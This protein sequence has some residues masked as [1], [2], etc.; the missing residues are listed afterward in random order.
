MLKP[1]AF[2]IVQSVNPDANPTVINDLLE[3]S[4]AKTQSG[5][6]T[7]RPY[8]VA[9][10]TLSLNPPN[11]NLKKA[12]TLEWFDWQSRVNQALA[13]QA[14][15]DASLIDIPSGWQTFPVAFSSFVS[16]SGLL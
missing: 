13:L 2:L 9:A 8:I 14:Q 10:H 5:T 7:Y 6:V 4:K 3:A 16:N 15:I 1:D 12:D 11:S